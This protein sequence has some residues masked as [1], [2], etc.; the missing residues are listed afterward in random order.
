VGTPLHFK[1]FLDGKRHLFSKDILEDSIFHLM[2]WY[3]TPLR[4]QTLFLSWSLW[5]HGV[6]YAS[7]YRPREL[8]TLDISYILFLKLWRYVYHLCY[9]DV[10]ARS[11]DF[12]DLYHYKCSSRGV[13]AYLVTTRPQSAH[14]RSRT[15]IRTRLDDPRPWLASLMVFS[16]RFRGVSRQN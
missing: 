13:F 8:D 7:R 16:R 15:S 6:R 14:D 11:H 3:E 5:T 2:T 1:E 9:H 4:S 10:L 12:F